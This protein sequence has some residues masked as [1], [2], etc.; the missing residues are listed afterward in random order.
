MLNSRA[1][2]PDETGVENQGKDLSVE[3]FDRVDSEKA[4]RASVDALKQCAE[5]FD[6]M[7]VDNCGIVVCGDTDLGRAL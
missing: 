2:V 1:K 3:V 6:L 4:I 5:L 7:P